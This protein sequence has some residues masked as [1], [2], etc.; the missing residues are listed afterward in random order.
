[1]SCPLQPLFLAYA[2]AAIELWQFDA[3]PFLSDISARIV[4]P[5]ELEPANAFAL[6]HFL[7]SLR[8]IP[9]SG[10]MNSFTGFLLSALAC[11]S[12]PLRAEAVGFLQS[13][14]DCVFT[15]DNWLGL[16]AGASESADLSLRCV[17]AGAVIRLRMGIPEPDIRRIAAVTLDYLRA[18]DE[19]CAAAACSVVLVAMELFDDELKD[20]LQAQG[21][22]LFER[23]ADRCG[24]G[25]WRSSERFLGFGYFGDA[26]LGRGRAFCFANR[27]ACLSRFGGGRMAHHFGEF[28]RLSAVDAFRQRVRPF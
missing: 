14:E 11:R 3:L 19:S 27:A 16:F 20:W 2:P 8:E 5:S 9:E 4:L 24:G 26:V 28:G 15:A 23:I 1:L 17:T 25:V 21:E 6:M 22:V 13:A 12:E 18:N 7:D 10:A